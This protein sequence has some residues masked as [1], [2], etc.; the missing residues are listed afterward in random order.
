MNTDFNTREEAL[1]FE[2]RRI[3]NYIKEIEI[4]P[5]NPQRDAGRLHILEDMQAR[6]EAILEMEEA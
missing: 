2:L 3:K 5:I 1:Q 6:I 4:N